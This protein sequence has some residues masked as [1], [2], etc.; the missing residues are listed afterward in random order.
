MLAP[1]R[2]EGYFV[3]LEPLITGPKKVSLAGRSRPD[4]LL[5]VCLDQRNLTAIELADHVQLYL[6]AGT[7]PIPV[8]V[9][10]G[11]LNDSMEGWFWVEHDRSPQL[12]AALPRGPVKDMSRYMWPFW[13]KAK[14][15][16]VL[17][18]PN[19]D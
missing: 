14:G 4:L 3:P 9:S 7:R 10:L 6:Q 13:G 16:A 2:L 11:L 8:R 15:E 12:S 1:M 19:S 18:W 5:E 17:V